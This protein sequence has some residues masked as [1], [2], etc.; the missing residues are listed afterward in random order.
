MKKNKLEKMLPYLLLLVITLIIGFPLLKLEMLRGDDGTF[1]LFRIYTTNIALREGQLIPMINPHML[2]GLGFCYNMFYG[3]LPPYI[4]TLLSLFLP[5]LG[6]AINLFIL[7]SIYLSGLTMYFFIKDLSKNKYVSL[8]AAIIYMTTPYHLYDIYDRMALGEVVSFVFIPLLFHGLHNIIFSKK[9]KWYLLTIA[10]AGLILTHTV[11]T[12]MVAIFACL[13]ILLNIKKVWHKDIIKKIIISLVV[14]LLISLPN[15]I[16]LIEAKLSSDYMVFDSSLMKTTGTQME[17]YSTSLLKLP[18]DP[19]QRISIFMFPLFIIIWIYFF[20]KRK[21]S[22][23]TPLYFPY[24]LLGSFSLLLTFSI[25]PWHL[26]PNILA[27][28]QFPWRYLQLTSF[29]LAIIISLIYGE[30]SC[31]LNK[32]YF[33]IGIFLCLLSSITMVGLGISKKTYSNDLV[34]D[35]DMVEKRGAPHSTG[36]AYS[37]YLPRNAIDKYEYFKSREDFVIL[38]GKSSITNYQKDKTKSSF[39]INVTSSSSIE[40]PYIYYPGYQVKINDKSISNYETNNGLLG[41]NLEKGNYHIQVKY[42]GT[43]LMIMSYFISLVT[44]ITFT[45]IIVKKCT[46]KN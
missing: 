23:I 35:N 18:L 5:T 7:L 9:D 15:I 14:A 27:T 13:Y 16:P 21:K 19:L 33:F 38:K 32:K 24:L 4:V 1:H 46:F 10:T 43:N 17:K 22:K 6:L 41:I 42:R 44:T 34:N 28:V 37:E 29:F 8:L 11:S 2:S 36:T 25:V 3:I 20:Y 39:D 40:L 45:L 31:L 30:F 12:F 26:L